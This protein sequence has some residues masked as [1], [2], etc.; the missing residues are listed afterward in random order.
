MKLLKL[1]DIYKLNIVLLIYKCTKFPTTRLSSYIDR[2][3][4]VLEHDIRYV[5]DFNLPHFR[6]NSVK[7]NFQYQALLHWNNL[8]ANIKNAKSIGVFKKLFIDYTTKGY[9]V[10]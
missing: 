7:F 4:R 1:F 6:I 2:Q 8:P 9:C 10:H 3:P 5:H